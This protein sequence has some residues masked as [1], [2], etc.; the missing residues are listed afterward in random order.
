MLSCVVFNLIGEELLM[1]V[2]GT[3]S[4]SLITNMSTLRKIQED[5]AEKMLKEGVERVI[6][7]MAEGFDE[8][9]A[10]AAIDAGVP[11]IAAVPNKGYGQYYWGANSLTRRNRLLEFNQLLDR[12]DEVVYICDGIY[13]NGRHAN[14]VRNEWMADHADRVWVYNPTSV[15][16]AH[17]YQYC[18]ARGIHTEVVRCI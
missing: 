12:A 11:F 8:C 16:T 18:Q 13:Q 14:F 1:V 6:S 9:I 10:M 7:G 15:G 17:C 2:A 5:L 3:G 4:R